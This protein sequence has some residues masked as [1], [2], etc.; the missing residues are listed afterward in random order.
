MDADGCIQEFEIA[1]EKGNLII[2]VGSTGYASRKIYEIVRES[3]DEYPYLSCYIEQLGT[4]T[5]INKLVEI[6]VKI[7]R[8]ESN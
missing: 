3:I 6:I 5:D 1:R 8:N 4:E 7:I 2:P